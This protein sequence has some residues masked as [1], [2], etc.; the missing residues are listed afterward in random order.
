MKDEETLSEIT[1]ANTTV[2][3][4][5]K[6]KNSPDKKY[7][8]V[9]IWLA[10]LDE[11]SE[12]FIDMFIHSPSLLPHPERNKIIILCGEKMKV[13]AYKLDPSGDECHSW[14]DMT[15]LYNITET[16]VESINLEDLLKST[17]RISEYIEKEAKYLN[18][19]DNIFL[20]GFSQGAIMSLH[21]GLSYEKLLGGIISCSG[22]LFPKTEINKN[23]EKLRIFISHGDLD[24]FIEIG[25][26]KLS[27]K[28]IQNFP[29]LEI[30]Y[31]PS[32]GHCI[33]QNALIDL[34]NFL[35]KYMK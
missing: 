29:N 31:Y 25:I 17:K 18:G 26:N 28:R 32:I 34:A 16:N 10:G 27:I 24:D 15:C 7:T 8:T 13:T 30:H 23:N 6:N 9:L 21:V 4:L 19:Y 20:G 33:E 11:S 1:K 5:P 22:A 12:D 3:L 14:F 35:Y 2:I